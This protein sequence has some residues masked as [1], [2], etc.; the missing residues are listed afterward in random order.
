MLYSS[1]KE[2]ERME[3]ETMNNYEIITN[4]IDQFA[5]LWRIK[6]AQPEGCY[7][8]V[9]DKELNTLEI[10]LHTFGINTDSLRQ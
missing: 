6:N 1:L 8:P 7:N 2:G 9:L 3:P 4:T 5:M 10:K